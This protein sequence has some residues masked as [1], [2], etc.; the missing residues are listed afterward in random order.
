VSR[1]LRTATRLI[2]DGELPVTASGLPVDFGEGLALPFDSDT[3]ENQFDTHYGLLSPEQTVLV[4]AYTD[5]SDDQ[6]LSEIKPRFII[7]FEPNMDFIRRIE[8][9]PAWESYL[10]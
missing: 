3:F 5:D 10:I 1:S 6:V 4:R 8:V 9:N 2:A 7:M